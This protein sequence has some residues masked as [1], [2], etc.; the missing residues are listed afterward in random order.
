MVLSTPSKKRILFLLIC[1]L[2]FNHFSIAE[3]SESIEK[4][5]TS[6]QSK[7]KVT[8]KAK[9]SQYPGKRMMLVSDL[10]GDI[11]VYLNN[12]QLKAKNLF[13]GEDVIIKGRTLK[14]M[15][16][17]NLVVSAESITRIP[18]TPPPAPAKSLATIPEDFSSLPRAK[19]AY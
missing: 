10:T 6:K 8:F 9:I 12:A 7:Q 1:L 4:I 13:K 16:N 14:T 18:N 3:K 5:K 11:Q 19:R 2:S 15:N 17:P